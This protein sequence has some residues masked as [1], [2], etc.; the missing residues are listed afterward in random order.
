MYMWI[1]IVVAG[2]G[3][4]SFHEFET[5]HQCLTVQK[6]VVGMLAATSA[7]Q[8]SCIAKPNRQEQ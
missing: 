5:Q 2:N 3:V 8:T 1:L 6:A 4:T 7:A